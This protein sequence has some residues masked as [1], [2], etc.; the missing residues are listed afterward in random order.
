MNI[1]LNLSK[2]NLISLSLKILS[3]LLKTPISVREE[4]TLIAFL[5]LP[6]KYQFAPF[7]SIPKRLIR[8]QLS[9]SPS[10]LNNR[11]YSLKK[12]GFI[13][14][15]DDELLSYHPLIKYVLSTKDTYSFNINGTLND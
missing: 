6:N 5:L 1:K 2:K 15:E 11:I 12:K 4:E 10:L 8:S 13:I 9:L 3:A 7:T 14:M